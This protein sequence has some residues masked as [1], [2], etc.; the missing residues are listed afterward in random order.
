MRITDESTKEKGIEFT[1]MGLLSIYKI[2]NHTD[3]FF[4][5]TSV[6]NNNDYNSINLKT[7]QNCRT[8]LNSRCKE[9]DAE[10][11]IR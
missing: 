5:K 10:L 8:S 3:D 9:F 11:I 2:L 7:L 1:K 6:Y 4:I